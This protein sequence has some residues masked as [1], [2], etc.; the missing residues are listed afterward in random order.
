M[1]RSLKPALCA[2]AAGGLDSG[3]IAAG[4]TW[5]TVLKRLGRVDYACTLHSAMTATLAVE[6]KR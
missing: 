2:W 3:P 6:E 1:T 5:S 4:T